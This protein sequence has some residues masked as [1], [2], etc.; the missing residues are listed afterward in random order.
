MKMQNSVIFAKKIL[1][2]NMWKTKKIVKLEI[3]VI[4]HGNIEVLRI[5]YLRSSYN[6][7]NYDYKKVSRG[8]L[9]NNLLV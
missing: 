6:G 5:T 7:S 1:K 3:I 9:K 2:I 4:M 8:I